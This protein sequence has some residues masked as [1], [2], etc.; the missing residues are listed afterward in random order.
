MEIT[1]EGAITVVRLTAPTLVEQWLIQVVGDELYRL[2]QESG[3]RILVDLGAVQQISSSV[4][5][6]LIELQRRLHLVG[7]RVAVC[8]L[9]PDVADLFRVTHIDQILRVAPDRQHGLRAL[10]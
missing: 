3:A 7:G 9:Q 10:A 4:V 2:A 8:C 6:K 5:A 1:K